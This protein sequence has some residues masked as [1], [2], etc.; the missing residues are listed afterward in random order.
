MSSSKGKDKDSVVEEVEEITASISDDVIDYVMVRMELFD[1]DGVIEEYISRYDFMGFQQDTYIKSLILKRSKKKIAKDEFEIDLVK[2]I[3]M[4]LKIGN[5]NDNNMG[6]RSQEA[7]DDWQQLKSRYNIVTNASGQDSRVVTIPRTASS[8]P[9]LTMRVA[10][11][12]GVRDFPGPFNSRSLPWYLKVSVF[13]ACVP[14]DMSEGT[15]NLL[16]AAAAAFSAEQSLAFPRSR[17]TPANSILIDQFKFILISYNSKYPSEESRSWYLNT[18]PI[19]DDYARIRA[20]SERVFTLVDDISSQVPLIESVTADTTSIS[21]KV[22][23]KPKRAMP[24]EPVG[25]EEA[26]YQGDK[27]EKPDQSSSKDKGKGKEKVEGKSDKE[28]FD[29]PSDSDEESSK[30][31]GIDK[32][33]NKFPS[34]LFYP[35]GLSSKKKKEFRTRKR[36]EG[37]KGGFATQP[38]DAI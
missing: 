16:L 19:I 30:D 6:R 9:I 26:G 3:V 20:V 13:P 27:H 32:E 17:G 38:D 15:R 34:L 28:K 5:P 22:S 1:L 24:E 25:F 2:M 31:Y 36:D 33:G 37:Y 18:L 11:R 35:V 21:A 29:L 14:H 12:V 8:F 23:Q 7:K 10:E 4:F